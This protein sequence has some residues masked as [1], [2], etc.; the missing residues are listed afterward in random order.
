MNENMW[1]P[2]HFGAPQ[3]TKTVILFVSWMPLATP[4][5]Q[6]TPP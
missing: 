2:V 4:L 3:I 5:P 1:M 6:K